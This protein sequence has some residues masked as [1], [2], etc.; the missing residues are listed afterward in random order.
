MPNSRLLAVSC[1]LAFLIA[2]SRA[3]LAQEARQS[4]ADGWP[5]YGHD[6]AGTRYSPLTQINRDN[7]SKLQVAWT[8]HVED[9]SDGSDGRKRTGL[10]TTPILVDGTLY[11]TSGYNRVFALDPETG[12]QKWVYDP[13][14]DTT[15]EYGDGLINRGV[16]TWFD[17]TRAKGK[18]AG[19]GFSS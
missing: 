4:G 5:A 12:K 18:P 6:A 15:V 11:L 7:V 14:V 8:F 2:G 16:A 3:T 9:L 13:M 19:G 10:E 17:A 1:L